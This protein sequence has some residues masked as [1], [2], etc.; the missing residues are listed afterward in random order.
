[1]LFR[2]LTFGALVESQTHPVST[3]GTSIVD[4]SKVSH[5]IYKGGIFGG[6]VNNFFS[7][8]VDKIMNST[9]GVIVRHPLKYTAHIGNSLQHCLSEG[10]IVD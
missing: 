5:E 10:R 8:A 7:C 3:K 6:L 4:Q 2:V 1:M 9:M